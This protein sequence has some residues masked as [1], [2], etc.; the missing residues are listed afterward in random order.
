[1][2]RIDLAS[3]VVRLEAQ[4]AQYQAQLQKAQGQLR[5]FQKS[6]GSIL[7]TLAA[8][9]SVREILGFTKGLIDAAD[10]MND[11]AKQ[12][13]VTVESLSQLKY[14][15]EQNGGD[16]DTLSQG[17]KLLAKNAAS[18]ADGTGASAQAFK[19]LGVS[20]TDTHGNLK[21]T[22]EILLSVAETFSKYADGAGKAAAAQEI[23]GKNG[24]ALIPFLNQG[25]SGIEALRKEADRLGIT[26]SGATA[27]A[28]DDF[29]DALSRAKSSIGG[30]ITGAIG[31]LLPKLTEAITQFTGAA[32]GAKA[33]DSALV[34]LQTGV[35]LLA[36]AGLTI[37][38]TFRLV[39]DQLGAMAAFF[40]KWSEH[41][42][43]GAYNVAKDAGQNFMSSQEKYAKSLE[44]VWSDSAEKVGKNWAKAAGRVKANL[45][46]LPTSSGDGLELVDIDA[47]KTQTD[48]MAL[49]YRT[50]DEGTQTSI[51]QAASGFYK[52]QAALEELRKTGESTNAEFA[53]F[54]ISGAEYTKRI[55]EALD[56]VL[57]E[58]KVSVK[59]IGDTWKTQFEHVNEY[60]VELQRNTQDI[61]GDSIY[62]AFTG[63]LDDIP[64]MFQKM[65][66]QLI[67]QAQAAK[68]ATYLF[69]A[70][71]EG[72]IGS[73]GSGF[74]G[75]LGSIA[76]KLFGGGR[77]K[78]GGVS[79]GKAYVVNENTPRSEIFTPS[80]AGRIDPA[81][82]GGGMQV[83]NNFSISAPNGTVSQA[84]QQQVA[85]AA[86][87]GIS[88]ASRRNN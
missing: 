5:S 10:H 83:V 29:N 7:K 18:A 22:E 84:T 78:G 86:A 82:A 26:M 81:G 21:P 63:K 74:L 34:P 51:E 44:T 37:A 79:P 2:A 3:M 42:L 56:E 20:V 59:K 19:R 73:G 69:G 66:L 38:Q 23:F 30:L 32:S 71:T 24:V 77:A 41:D 58:M 64:S 28:A 75:T 25:R 12:T 14:A 39:G 35:K 8:A 31:P 87:R 4:T 45:P 65:I 16:I 52:T 50:L 67:A 15:A 57:P 85:A 17:L 1:M 9:W 6:S 40:V 47:V 11:L 33:L 53:K 62:D 46:Q 43:V 27:Q 80:V 61:L 88:N 54:G 13:G 55:T 68:L 60:V 76:S 49:F 48:A 72:G 36:S 70:K